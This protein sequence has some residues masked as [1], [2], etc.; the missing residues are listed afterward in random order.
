MPFSPGARYSQGYSLTELVIVL[1]IIGL[2]SGLTVSIGKV[3]L[4]VVE[5]QGTKERLDTVRSAL[6][7]F[8]K[9]HKRYP[10]PALPGDSTASASYGL[11]VD[12]VIGCD[13]ACPAELTCDNS[14]VIGAVPFKTLKLNEEVAYDSWDGKITFPRIKW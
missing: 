8:Q 10:C 13:A 12:A 2:V 11:E 14:A 1:A 4:S 9:K 6:Q 3:Q 7:L 5:I